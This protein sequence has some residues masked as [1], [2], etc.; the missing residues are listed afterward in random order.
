MDLE[1]SDEQTWLSRVR[2]DAARPRVEARARRAVRRRPTRATGCGGLVDFGALAVGGDDGLGAVELCLIAR[3]LGAHL[4][5]VPYLGERRGAL[6]GRVLRPRRA[7]RRRDAV[8][9]AMLEPGSGWARRAADRRST[10]HRPTSQR[11][12][13]RASSTRRRPAGSRSSRRRPTARRSPWCAPRAAGVEPAEQAAFDATVPMYAVDLA[14]AAVGGGTRPRRRGAASR[15]S[16]RSARCSPPPRPSG[17]QGG[18]ST[19]PAATPASGASS[20]A[21]S[22]ASRRCATCS[23]TCTSARRARGRRSCTPRRRS[24]RTPARPGARRRSPR[25]TCARRPRGG[26][27]RD[28]GLRRASR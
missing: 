9:L 12:Q 3:A 24:T 17:R 6:R 18:C 28:A 11:A 25:R 16:R 5:P 4:A 8:A 26:P 14:A 23:P 1:L 2:R 10:G 27:R 19:T 21:R 7:V 20:A 15:G 13:G 22:A